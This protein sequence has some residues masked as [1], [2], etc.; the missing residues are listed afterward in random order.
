M[1]GLGQLDVV[2]MEERSSGHG[3]YRRRPGQQ[4]KLQHYNG[5]AKSAS[6]PIPIPM[7]KPQPKLNPKTN[8]HS[9]GA[10]PHARRSMIPFPSFPSFAFS[11]SCDL[12]FGHA[13][14]LAPINKSGAGSK[15]P[16]PRSP[17][18]QAQSDPS[19]VQLQLQL[20]LQSQVE[21]SARRQWNVY[22]PHISK[23][24]DLDGLEDGLMYT[25]MC[26]NCHAKWSYKFMNAKKAAALLPFSTPW[27]SL[28]MYIYI[29]SFAYFCFSTI[30]GMCAASICEVDLA[31]GTRQY[32]NP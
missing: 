2:S 29:F 30:S 16:H 21:A 12:H 26:C 32:K 28:Y 15:T 5:Q 11:C 8:P 13:A 24:C 17:E 27:A 25:R 31:H 10:T 4:W 14:A 19:W 9:C 6:I 23:H 1:K 18:D 7:P 3:S 22:F 20:R